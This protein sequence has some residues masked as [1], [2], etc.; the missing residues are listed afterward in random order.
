M[1]PLEEQILKAA[2]AMA[3]F[4]EFLTRETD[5]LGRFDVAFT[6]KNHTH[7]MALA[8]S[9]LQSI[10]ALRDNKA[11]ISALKA[12]NPEVPAQMH[13]AW[14]T[15]NSIVTANAAALKRAEGI[16]RRVIDVLVDATRKSNAPVTTRY[17][18][19]AVTTPRG[20]LS[21]SLNRTF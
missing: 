19:R 2:A 16:S 15:M 6:S 12:E 5:A 10:N 9:V 13:S 3:D 11:E 14:E 4:T 7:K 8:R 20:P 1:T 17:S 18:R 21:V